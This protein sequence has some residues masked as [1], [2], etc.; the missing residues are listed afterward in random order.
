MEQISCPACGKAYQVD[1]SYYGKSFQCNC[2]QM[3]NVPAPG[4]GVPP[5]PPPPQQPG[6]APPQPGYAQ[7]RYGQ[8][9]YAPPQPTGTPGIVIAGFIFSFLCG[10]LG[11]ILCAVGLGEA[12]KRGAGEG[13]AI[14]GI[15]ISI[16]NMLLGVVISIAQNA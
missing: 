13:L 12:K 6:Y 9:G 7:P 15:I 8:P 3:V 11:L 5:P 16:V 1:A 14:A 4:A 2:G 10:L